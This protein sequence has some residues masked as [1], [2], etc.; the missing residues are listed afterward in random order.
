V[1]EGHL[2]AY[3]NVPIGKAVD[4]F[5]TSPA[6]KVVP[7]HDAT[8]YVNFSGGAIYCNKPIQVTLQCQVNRSVGSFEVNALEM[9]DI[10]QDN[11]MKAAFLSTLVESYKQ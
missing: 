2:K 4:A 5:H 10:P 6:W 3:P 8:E 7:G 1:K 9:N 11:L